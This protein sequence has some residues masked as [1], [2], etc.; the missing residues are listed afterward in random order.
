MRFFLFPFS[1]LALKPRRP[2][3]DDGCRGSRIVPSSFAVTLN[4]K[5]GGRG[6]MLPPPSSSSRLLPRTTLSS[7]KSCLTIVGAAAVAAVAAVGV[8]FLVRGR[9]GEEDKRDSCVIS[10]RDVVAFNHNKNLTPNMDPEKG[11]LDSV[12]F[13]KE[14]C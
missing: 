4:T 3:L 1:S 13:E 11:F 7:A 12:I 2:M 5:G 6:G 14:K 9:K 10:S 8:V